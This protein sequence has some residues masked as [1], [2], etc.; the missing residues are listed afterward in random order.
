MNIAKFEIEQWMNDYEQKAKYNIAESCADIIS[1]E[2]LLEIVGEDK[3]TY[4]TRLTSMKLSY[5]S[6]QGREELKE[7]ICRLY[8][9]IKKENVL[10]THGG[11]G[12]NNS[13]LFSLLEEGDE[14]I[15]LYPTYQQLYSVPESIGA[16]VK[17][18]KTEKEDNFLPRVEELKK[19]ITDKTKLI[20]IN[21]PNNP[22]GALISETA[23]REISSEARRV[24]A[25]ILCDEAY[26]GLSHDGSYTPSIIDI[27]EKG[28]STGSMSK[29]FSLPG[30]RIGWIATKAKE[31]IHKLLERRDYDIISCSM[32][33]EAIAALALKNSDK[34]IKR[35]LTLVNRNIEVLDRWISSQEHFSYIKPKASTVTLLFYDFPIPSKE[36]SLRL[37]EETGVFLTPGSCFGVEGSLRIGYAASIEVLEKALELLA[38]FSKKLSRAA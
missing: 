29:V 13:V 5:G 8:K 22:T 24:G 16:K 36:F 3:N 10:S 7:G 20:C 9:D 32:L 37:L 28:I 23:L 21:N 1:L 15:A 35:N 26:R 14:V 30:L 31:V 33:D 25:Y 12:G 2:E 34:L 38:Q 17:Y 4:M 27:Y 6:I 11:I 19:L 18:L